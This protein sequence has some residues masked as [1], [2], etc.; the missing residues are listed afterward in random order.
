MPCQMTHHQKGVPI[1]RPW[2]S[3]IGWR[4]DGGN[5]RWNSDHLKIWKSKDSQKGIFVKRWILDA[6]LACYVRCNIDTNFKCHISKR[7]ISEDIMVGLRTKARWQNWEVELKPFKNL[8]IL[9]SGVHL[10]G[11]FAK[12]ECWMLDGS[13]RTIRISK[14]IGFL[15]MVFL[16]NFRCGT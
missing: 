8:K 2:W 14:N 12:F 6:T 9:K 16:E 5:G 13:I 1:N 10:N 11:I 4:S 15:E 7:P 3:F